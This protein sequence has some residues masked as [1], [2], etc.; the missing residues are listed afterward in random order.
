MAP[1]SDSNKMRFKLW[2]GLVEFFVC[3]GKKMRFCLAFFFVCSA[4]AIIPYYKFPIEGQ[5]ICEP[6]PGTR[7]GVNALVE[8]W[9]EDKS[10]FFGKKRI[11][12]DENF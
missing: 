8:V 10:E 12:F 4:N 9:E 2:S 5:L 3:W 11:R 1:P 7:L 6:T